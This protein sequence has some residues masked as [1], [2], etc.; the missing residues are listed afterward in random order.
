MTRSSGNCAHVFRLG[1]M[2]R[3]SI[4]IVVSANGYGH[5]RRQL[6]V[7]RCLLERNSSLSLVFGITEAQ[8]KR[9][10]SDFSELG[11]R[12]IVLPGVTENSPRW[13]HRP[14]DY[15]YEN[16]SGWV[17]VFAS[18]Q[19]METDYVLSDNLVEVLAVRPDSWLSGSFL[20]S[21]VL[22]T[23]SQESHACETFVARENALLQSVQPHMLANKYLATPEVRRKTRIV[24]LGWVIEEPTVNTLAQRDVVL[25]HGGG[26]RTLD[27]LVATL[28]NTLRENGLRVM[29]DLE[30]DL[31]RFDYSEGT[32]AQVGLVICRPGIG[33]VT[34]CVK[35]RTPMLLIP[36]TTNSEA[37]HV[38]RTLERSAVASVLHEGDK[39]PPEL[40]VARI[41]Q[42]LKST[43]EAY[44]VYD[45]NGIEQAAQWIEGQL[46]RSTSTSSS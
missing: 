20:W 38:I 35:W 37:M 6:Q 16:L 12:V 45:R 25:I 32:W 15:T 28:A 2:R 11:S 5:I 4:G 36:D 26:T 46:W 29:T 10:F 3:Y 39:V 21:D 8:H 22:E 40:L 31:D 30:N 18:S 9:F 7:T 14:L 44:D 17:E 13:K 24:E 41:H 33:T 19:L 42:L 34:E 23:H 27:S 43:T 1:Q